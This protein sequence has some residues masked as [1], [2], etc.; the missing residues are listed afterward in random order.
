L[1]LRHSEPQ[2]PDP[3]L[4]GNAGSASVYYK[5]STGTVK[6]GDFVP[7]SF[8]SKQDDQP[9]MFGCCDENMLRDEITGTH[10]KLGRKIGFAVPLICTQGYK[11]NAQKIYPTFF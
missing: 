5:Y 10:R 2:D 8:F 9:K 3:K 7:F 1:K 4:C 6:S 11:T